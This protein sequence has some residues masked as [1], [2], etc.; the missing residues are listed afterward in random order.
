VDSKTKVE[1]KE[2]SLINSK[3]TKRNALNFKGSSPL[4]KHS[5]SKSITHMNFE[6]Q[7]KVKPRDKENSNANDEESSVLKTHLQSLKKRKT[8]LEKDLQDETQR[9]N[10]TRGSLVETVKR[11]NDL[12]KSIKWKREIEK[13]LK[14][15]EKSLKAIKSKIR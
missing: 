1:R 2:I 4:V 3:R 9:L 6:I 10:T 15:V 5:Q 8:K 14:L 13:D 11:G 12:E 7:P